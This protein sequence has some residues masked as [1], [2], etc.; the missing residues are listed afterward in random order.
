VPNSLTSGIKSYTAAMERAAK[1]VFAT[2]GIDFVGRNYAMGGKYVINYRSEEEV[3]QDSQSLM[4]QVLRVDRN[5][6]CVSMPFMGLILM[7]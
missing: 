1:G 7:C 3:T 2:A 6:D 5:V 4:L